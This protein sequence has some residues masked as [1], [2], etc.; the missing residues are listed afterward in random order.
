M[1]D[2]L[3]EKIQ[4]V[5]I[6]IGSPIRDKLLIIVISFNAEQITISLEDITDLCIF[7]QIIIKRY[8]L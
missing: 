1:Y 6:S 4:V 3:F 7:K 8:F 2:T 5:R